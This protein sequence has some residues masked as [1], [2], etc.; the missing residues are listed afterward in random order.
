MLL[1]AKMLELP[2]VLMTDLYGVCV[3]INYLLN[4]QYFIMAYE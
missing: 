3:L 2:V 1:T 4:G